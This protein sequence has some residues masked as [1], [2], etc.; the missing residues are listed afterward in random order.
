MLALFWGALAVLAVLFARAAAFCIF[1]AILIVRPAPSTSLPAVLSSIKLIVVGSGIAL[2]SGHLSWFFAAL[3]NASTA[4]AALYVLALLV[5]MPTFEPR[6]MKTIITSI[7]LW[8]AWILGIS[9]LWLS[10][11]PG[12][13]GAL[14]F[15]QA[16][17]GWLAAHSPPSP[18]VPAPLGS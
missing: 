12:I 14:D 18:G 3:A 2:L 5:S 9:C 16:L 11:L 8:C 6:D 4:F 1:G 13:A 15:W 17:L 10:S 7:A